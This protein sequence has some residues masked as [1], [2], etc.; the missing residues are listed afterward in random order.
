MRRFR[1]GAMTVALWTILCIGCS[2][3]APKDKVINTDAYDAEMQAAIASARAKL[4]EFWQIFDKRPNGESNFSLKLHV[5][6]GNGDEHFWVIDIEKKDEKGFGTINN[7]PNT[8]KSV[9]LGQRVEVPNDRISDWLY[10]RNGKI[11]GNFTLRPLM[12]QMPPEE[13]AKLKSILAEP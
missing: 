6:D 10:M 12:K 5:T 7:D 11:V 9:K 8:V 2:R 3:T 1:F 4:P 13:V